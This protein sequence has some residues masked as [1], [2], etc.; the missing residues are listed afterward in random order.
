MLAATYLLATIEPDV[1]VGPLPDERLP[2]LA[3][4]HGSPKILPATLSSVDIAGIV[5]GAG[6]QVDDV[7]AHQ[8]APSP[9]A[10]RGTLSTGCFD[11][12]ARPWRLG[13]AQRPGRIC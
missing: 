11:G 9:L 4:V 7:L 1:G 12:A 13:H 3:K 5:K 6:L 10:R 2:E 8:V